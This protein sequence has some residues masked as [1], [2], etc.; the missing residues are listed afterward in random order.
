MKAIK[1]KVK[2]AIFL[3]SYVAMAQLKGNNERVGSLLTCYW[4]TCYS[5]MLST[6]SSLKDL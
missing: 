2:F 6:M 1:P 5:Q 4:L 3:V